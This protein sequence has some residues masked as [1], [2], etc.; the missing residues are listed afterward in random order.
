MNKRS[1]LKHL[2]LL[3]MAAVAIMACGGSDDPENPDVNPSQTNV[4]RNNTAQNAVYGRMEFP[5]LKGGS[6][7][8]VII[9]TVPE[10]GV[11]YCV[12]W[13]SDLK[14]EGWTP[15]G[16]LR[17][18]RWSC[19]Q[20]HAGN[21][22]SKTD[23]KPY[24]EGGEFSEYPNDP[25]LSSKYHFTSDPYR[26]SGY[27]HGHIIASADRA[28]SF[29]YRANTQTFYMTNIYPMVHNFNGGIWA[30]MEKRVRI[31]GGQADTLYV[32]KGGTIDK[33]DG[34]LNYTKGNHIVPKYFY[35]AVLH[36]NK[37]SNTY[38]GVAFWT[39]HQNASDTTTD[40]STFAISIDELERRTGIDFFCN[41]PDEIED[42]VEA[43][44]DFEFWKFVNA[45]Q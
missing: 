43:N 32:C 5:R 37:A 35:M 11:N 4:N 22:S 44:V 9:H 17:S 13:D 34:I 39:L 30:T 41:L 38:Q 33:A 19:Y 24:N 25:D 20:M 36:Y 29:N 45:A 18:Q 7:N 27:D 2:I 15:E 10:F 40:L 14:P 26:F 6:N 31:W 28:F 16:T 21:S 1:N 8:I 23:R 42:V 12:E 3:L